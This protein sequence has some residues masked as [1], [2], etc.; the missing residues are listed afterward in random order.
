MDLPEEEVTE[1][2]LKGQKCTKMKRSMEGRV[3]K[4]L[5]KETEVSES[6]MIPPE[7]KKNLKKPCK[8]TQLFI[9]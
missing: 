9:R 5:Q 1:K 3:L 2:T 6:L 8:G 7:E 4:W